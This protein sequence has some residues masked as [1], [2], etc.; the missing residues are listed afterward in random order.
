M[1]QL[2]TG[3]REEPG[4][5]GGAASTTRPWSSSP[6]LGLGRE[7]V[8]CADSIQ[9]TATLVRRRDPGPLLQIHAELDALLQEGLASAVGFCFCTSAD[10]RRIEGAQPPSGRGSAAAVK[11]E[12]GRWAYRSRPRGHGGQ[13]RRR[14]P[15]AVVEGKGERNPGMRLGEGVPSF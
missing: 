12:E 10:S 14:A 7:E 4:A 15:R 3:I 2:L 1:G 6:D 5:N 8:G 13:S 9:A 11:V